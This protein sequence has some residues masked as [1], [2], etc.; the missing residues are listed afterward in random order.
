MLMPH[1]ETLRKLVEEYEALAD[2]EAA[3]AV[4]RPGQR[5]QDL[6]YTLCVSTGTRD[7]RRALAAARQQ[8]AA[9]ATPVSPAPQGTLGR[10]T[11]GRRVI[12]NGRPLGLG[13]GVPDAETP[14]MSD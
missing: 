5:A 13:V 9:T 1:P 2:Q 10:T 4:G 6:A 8:L 12:T 14:V 7:V 3:D 11:V